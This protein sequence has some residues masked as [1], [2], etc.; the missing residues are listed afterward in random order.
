[1]K[2]FIHMEDNEDGTMTMT[3]CVDEENEDTFLL[4]MSFDD[5]IASITNNEGVRALAIGVSETL[6]EI[7]NQV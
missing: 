6:I 1:M 2:R 4:Q 7:P 5:I 3:M